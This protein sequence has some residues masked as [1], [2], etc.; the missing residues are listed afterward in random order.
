MRMREGS[1]GVPAEVR[2]CV[3]L[4]GEGGSNWSASPSHGEKERG[5][6]STYLEVRLNTART[7]TSSVFAS[8]QSSYVSKGP[9]QLAPAL[10][11][12]IFNF[13]SSGSSPFNF[14]ISRSNPS[15]RPTLAAMYV[16][17]PLMPGMAL[18]CD[19]AFARLASLRAVRITLEAPA[20][21][22]AAAM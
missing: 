21:R 13:P 19:A 14:S 22:K 3:S 20:W 18:S 16:A 7:L 4:M 11:T 1:S 15:G 8:F 6:D 17:R 12:R 9:A 5:E 2:W 10:L